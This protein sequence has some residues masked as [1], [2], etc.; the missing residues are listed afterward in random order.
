[1]FCPLQFALVETSEILL[2]CTGI[3]GDFFHHRG[4]R[5]PPLCWGRH[6]L[7]SLQ[8]GQ[9]RKMFLV[10]LLSFL[11][12][13]LRSTRPALSAADLTQSRQICQVSGYLR[14]ITVSGRLSKTEDVEGPQ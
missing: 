14:R 5:P 2:S 3:E 12:D 13:F 7:H 8:T 4:L 11:L 10:G 1:M 9:G 6:F